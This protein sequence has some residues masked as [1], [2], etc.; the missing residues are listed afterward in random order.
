MLRCTKVAGPRWGPGSRGACSSARN[1]CPHINLSSWIRMFLCLLDPDP[2]PL[3]RGMD[4]DSDPALDKITPKSGRKKINSSQDPCFVSSLKCLLS[5][6]RN[7]R[8]MVLKQTQGMNVIREKLWL[9]Y[10]WTKKNIIAT[11]QY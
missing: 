6:K 7:K 10:A 5:I 3:V 4:P 2:D 9:A 11:Y 8:Q 1:T